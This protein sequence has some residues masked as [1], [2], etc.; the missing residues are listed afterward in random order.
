MYR[1]RFTDTARQKDVLQETFI[2][3]TSAWVNM[4][5]MSATGPIRTPVGACATAIESLD[6]GY[7]A[8]VSGRCKLALVG[9]TDDFAEE[10]SYE[11]RKMKATNNSTEDFMHG[12]RPREM[13]RPCTS[14]RAGFVESQGAGIQV[15]MSA[16]LALEMGA[17]IHAIVGNTTMAGD[18]I[19]RSVPAPGQGILS[20]CAENSTESP[21]PLLDIN[22]RKVQLTRSLRRIQDQENNDIWEAVTT[23]ATNS[24]RVSNDAVTQIRSNARRQAKQTIAYWGT[25]F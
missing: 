14:T 25:E 2:N 1:D 18:N 15:L 3:T 21:S 23:S 19:S 10:N 12:R 24:D 16:S 11:F 7:E 5:L 8:I 20:S 9:G 4:L 22:Y 13:S 6:L 17:P